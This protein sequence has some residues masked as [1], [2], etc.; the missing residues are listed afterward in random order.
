VTSNGDHDVSSFKF[1][2]FP[3]LSRSHTK[4]PLGI[5]RWLERPSDKG[6]VPCSSRMAIRCLGVSLVGRS[7]ALSRM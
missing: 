3:N 6:E 5:S 1:I 7:A 4:V 2:L